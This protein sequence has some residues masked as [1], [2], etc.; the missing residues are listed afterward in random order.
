MKA[1]Y[2]VIEATVGDSMLDVQRHSTHRFSF[3]GYDDDSPFVVE[4]PV[5]LKYGRGAD[6]FVFQP[7]SYLWISQFGGRVHA[8][9]Y[10][11][12]LEPL[13]WEQGVRMSWALMEQFNA[14]PWKPESSKTRSVE[15]VREDFDAA[16]RETY[17]SKIQSWRLGDARLLLVLKRLR[18]P[19]DPED[20]AQRE[21]FIVVLTFD[22][23]ALRDRLIEQ[24]D[25]KRREHGSENDPLPLEHWLEGGGKIH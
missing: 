13:S 21:T 15:E 25:K 23:W 20:P 17:A 3:E 14:S 12:H 22:D 10:A 2:P 9:Q 24:V 8:I 1:G 4:T 16:T 7:G 18:K 19:E 5:V 11:P 6:G